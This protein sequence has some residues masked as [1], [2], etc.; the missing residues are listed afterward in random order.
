MRYKTISTENFSLNV[1]EMRR[2][3][4]CAKTLVCRI[5]IEFLP[6]FKFLK[7]VVPDHISHE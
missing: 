6:K 1:N 4:D 3:V 7:A 5:V 2:Y